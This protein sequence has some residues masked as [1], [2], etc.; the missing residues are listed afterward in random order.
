M[1]PLSNLPPSI[2]LV[3]HGQFSKEKQAIDELAARLDPQEIV[4]HGESL[5]CGTFGKGYQLQV[6]G[7]TYVAKNFGHAES[8]VGSFG[9]VSVADFQMMALKQ[10]AMHNALAL[11]GLPIP[12]AAV[13]AKDPSWVV[14]KKVEGLGFKE[15]SDSEQTEAKVVAGY[16]RS[17]LEPLLQVPLQALQR[18]HP[19]SEVF[20]SLTVDD[21]TDNMR[22]AREPSGLKL[23]GFYDPVV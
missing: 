15:L 16:L 2:Q 22:F 19:S 12:V 14:M 17:N 9:T 1:N 6:D 8:V 5:G 18:E 3:S 20:Q 7:Q 11:A 10:A 21:E 23:Q 4:S 13:I